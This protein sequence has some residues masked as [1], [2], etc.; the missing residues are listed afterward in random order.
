MQPPCHVAQ[1][2]KPRSIEHFEKFEKG[3]SPNSIEQV[4]EALDVLVPLLLDS[5]ETMAAVFGP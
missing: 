1:L 4:Q 5:I 3:L 2:D